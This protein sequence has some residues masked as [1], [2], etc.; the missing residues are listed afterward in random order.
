[1]DYFVSFNSHNQYID[2]IAQ[3]G[4]IGFFCFTWFV[5]QVGK[6]GLSLRKT[7]PEGFPRTYVVGA[8][9]GLIGTLVAGMLGDWFI[10]FVYNIGYAG[11]RTSVLGWIFLGGLIALENISKIKASEQ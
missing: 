4:L 7:A 8:L 2:I 11:F 1:M 3:T 6:L 9:G 10:P 5:W